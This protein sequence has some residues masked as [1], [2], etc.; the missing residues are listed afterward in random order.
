[1][2][3][4]LNS[5]NS[6]SGSHLL[7]L[8]QDYVEVHLLFS[9]NQSSNTSFNPYKIMSALPFVIL[10]ENFKSI[11]DNCSTYPTA[12]LLCKNN[13]YMKYLPSNSTTFIQI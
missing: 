6:P 2:K 5:V 7:I 9:G 11:L 10:T 12:E 1:M 13:M 8:L 4:R 3:E